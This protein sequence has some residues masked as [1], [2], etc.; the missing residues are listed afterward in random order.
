MDW[1]NFIELFADDDYVAMYELIVKMSSKERSIAA[2]ILGED[3]DYLVYKHFNLLLEHLDTIKYVDLLSN[4]E[5]R[6]NIA[7]LKVWY[8]DIEE[9][10]MYRI[11]TDTDTYENNSEVISIVKDKDV[12]ELVL[13]Y[14]K[15]VSAVLV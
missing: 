10:Y 9:C 14:C 8:D 11:T 1:N 3:E 13:R 7:S 4:I 2:K 12:V 5:L 6:Y 15:L